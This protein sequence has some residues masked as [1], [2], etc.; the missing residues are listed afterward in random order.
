MTKCEKK[1]G[2]VKAAVVK[3]LDPVPTHHSGLKRNKKIY[4]LHWQIRDRYIS[5]YKSL[6]SDTS[7]RR[8]PHPTWDNCWTQ[9][10][11][12]K[13]IQNSL[14][15][16]DLDTALDIY[17][18]HHPETAEWPVRFIGVQPMETK[19]EVLK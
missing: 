3:R 5:S 19:R 13:K 8:M 15:S 6:K 12:A 18:K 17:A 1:I 4:P 14:S 10:E 9:S 11:D 7:W 16:G 2:I